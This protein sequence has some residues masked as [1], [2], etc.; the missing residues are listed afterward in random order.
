MR[1]V[2]PLKH[3]QRRQQIL[4]AAAACFVS[5]GFRGA[6]ISDICAAAQMSSGHL[7][8]Y[9]PSKEAIFQ[10]IVEARLSRATVEIQEVMT[11]ADPIE[12]FIDR[13]CDT[14]SSQR[15]DAQK[16]LLLEMLAEAQRNQIIG[17]ILHN[18]S[19]EVKTLLSRFLK[20]AQDTGKIDRSLNPDLLSSL[21]LVIIDGIQAMSARSPLA[22]ESER[23]AAAELLI[24]NLLRPQVPH[25]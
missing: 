14:I 7:Y 16:S 12:Y 1:T 11:S 8:H 20:D 9:F 22:T 10:A 25:I 15:E 3:E 6:S 19:T 13:V 21:L 24:T 23:R 2:D 4:K 18:H 5:D 17:E